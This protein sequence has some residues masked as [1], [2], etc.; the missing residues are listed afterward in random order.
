[1]QNYVHSVQNVAHMRFFSCRDREFLNQEISPK[2]KG[3]P[4]RKICT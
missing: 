2:A 1:M 3:L 4:T